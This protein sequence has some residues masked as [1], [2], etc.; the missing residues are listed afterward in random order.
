MEELR[1]AIK[2]DGLEAYVRA[3]FSKRK[4]EGG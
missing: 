2:E 1:E 4:K 3:F